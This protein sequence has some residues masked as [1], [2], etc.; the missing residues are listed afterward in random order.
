MSPL[1]LQPRSNKTEQ[2]IQTKISSLNYTQ[3]TKNTEWS[4]GGRVRKSV[5]E[6]GEQHVAGDGSKKWGF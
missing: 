2:N 5:E 1:S 6:D 4:F 3:S